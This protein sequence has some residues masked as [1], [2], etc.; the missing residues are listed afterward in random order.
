MKLVTADTGFAA[1]GA[2]EAT[3][4]A[5]AFAET[6]RCQPS[7]LRA[8]LDALTDPG[9]IDAGLSRFGRSLGCLP[10]ARFARFYYEELLRRSPESQ[11]VAIT[12]VEDPAAIIAAFLC[13]D[14]FIRRHCQLVLNEFGHLHR[15]LV[16]HVPKTGGTTLSAALQST[17]EYA[18]IADDGYVLSQPMDRLLYLWD[19]IVDL[20]RPE[21]TKV[22]IDSHINAN[23]IIGNSLKRGQ[24]KVYGL[25]RNPVEIAISFVN[26]ILTCLTPGFAHHENPRRREWLGLAEDEFVATP[27]QGVAL[28]PKI[29]E[30]MLPEQQLCMWFGTESSC[31]SAIATSIILDVE[32]IEMAKVDEFI[33]YKGLRPAQ[34]HNV[35]HRFVT[36][37]DLEE[38][39]RQM[40]IDR[41]REDMRFFEWIREHR[42]P[43]AG[44]TFKLA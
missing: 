23:Y 12:P 13:S 38:R 26:Y 14:E 39:A 3:P 24:D 9:G 16:I 35:S 22:Y 33:A 31:E 42:I 5:A 17:P 11:A 20:S 34:K 25:L 2:A 36:L 7:I 40:I 1:L 43:S 27:A 15:D 21:A 6:G 44:P 41:T 18:R 8:A 32:F 29:I 30:R 10:E 37:S 4:R 19:R 28:A